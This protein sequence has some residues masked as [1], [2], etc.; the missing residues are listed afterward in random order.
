MSG[1]HVVLALLLYAAVATALGHVD[2]H[3]RSDRE[4]GYAEFVPSV[5]A[6]REPPP[7][8]YRVFAPY[9]YEGV[10]QATTLAPREAWVLFRW[11]CTFAALM[12]LHAYLT[13]WFEFPVVV[14]GTVLAAALLP[15][16]FTNGWAHP[17]HLTEFFL[18]TLACWCLARG[19]WLVAL[20]V[21]AANALNRETSAFLIP[22]AFF[23]HAIT[24]RHV[25]RTAGLTAV[26]LG[27]TFGLR[28][29]FGWQTYDPWQV[30]QNL[31]FLKLLPD[32]YDPYYRMYA[33]FGVILAAPLGWATWMAWP[34]LP[35]YV[36]VSAGLVA[37][38][39][40]LTCFLFSSIIEVRILTPLIPLM[41]P[42][43]L[44]AMASPATTTSA[45]PRR[46]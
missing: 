42:A 32:T 3:I 14:A 35:R 2:Y 8:R 10:R 17:D 16:T 21:V 37:P 23:A 29:H 26:W 34:R 30:S 45:S 25:V 6:G 4:H 44:F 9:A 15:L 19:R 46:E 13:V 43:A 36:R 31:G 11:L 20:P 18:F 5:M 33:W 7:A 39:F 40:V 38:A 12:A 22:L 24:P 1:R 27:V 28:W 41:L